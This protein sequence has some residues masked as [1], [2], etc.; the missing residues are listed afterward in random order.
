[1]SARVWS[2]RKAPNGFYSW[3]D[4]AHKRHLKRTYTDP[5]CLYCAA[6]EALR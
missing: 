3:L 2:W 5:T 1:M 4:R 6:R